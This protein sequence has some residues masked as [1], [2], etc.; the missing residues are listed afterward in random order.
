MVVVL[1]VLGA[2]ALSEV[3]ARLSASLFCR[4]MDRRRRRP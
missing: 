4:W 1:L 2:L 3:V